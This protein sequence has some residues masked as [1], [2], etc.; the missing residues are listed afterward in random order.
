MCGEIIRSIHL[1]GAFLDGMG[2]RVAKA[3][4]SVAHL[5]DPLY[6][7]SFASLVIVRFMRYCIVRT[8]VAMGESKRAKRLSSAPSFLILGLEILEEQK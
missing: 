3:M 8:T 5:S 4:A 1:T 7:K 6:V 2:F